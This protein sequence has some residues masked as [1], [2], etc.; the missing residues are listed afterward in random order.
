MGR[1][2]HLVGYD[3]QQSFGAT[4]S[5]CW[6]VDEPRRKFAA[7]PVTL[8]RVDRRPGRCRDRKTRTRLISEERRPAPWAARDLNNTHVYFCVSSY[9]P[10]ETDGPRPWPT[11]SS[12]VDGR[13]EGAT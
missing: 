11:S 3:I 1:R 6:H 8:H 12:V 7:R 4:A 13:C 5:L 9:K 2:R 10:M